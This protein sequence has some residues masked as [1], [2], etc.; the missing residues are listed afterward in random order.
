MTP[1]ALIGSSGTTAAR[2]A[3]CCVQCRRPWANEPGTSDLALCAGC[4]APIRVDAVA[5]DFVSACAPPLSPGARVMQSRPL[6]RVYE[7]LWRPLLF[8]LSTG[9]GAPGAKEE[10]REV[11]RLLEGCADPWLDLSCGPGSLLREIVTA[12][13]SRDGTSPASPE[14]GRN[15][16]VFGLD[17]SRAMLERARLAA[18]RA[19]LVRADAADLPF[20]DATFGAIANLAA[21]DLYPDPSRV[22]AEAARVLAPGG[23]WV[24]ST[25]VRRA[26][27]PAS[28]RSSTTGVRT[29]AID[30]V[31]H[32]ARC[33]GLGRF[34][35]RLFR[36]YAI[37]WADKS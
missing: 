26:G 2:P 4:G 6:A 18:P 28:R 14:R 9:F 10:A 25:F 1:A 12:N 8:G 15:R 30:E 5:V 24:C 31:A 20:A 3:M 19:T 16:E 17:R 22:V 37:A 32:W 33:A 29:P 35:Q 23:R 7:G 34:G 13:A 36:R 27:T 11:L 21:L